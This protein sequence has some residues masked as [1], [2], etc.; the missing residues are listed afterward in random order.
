MNGRRARKKSR[1]RR[2]RALLRTLRALYPKG[3]I[4]IRERNKER[5]EKRNPSRKKQKKKSSKFGGVRGHQNFERNKTKKAGPSTV[6]APFFLLHCL[7]AIYYY[8]I[9]GWDSR[10]FVFS[11]RRAH[12]RGGEYL[13]FYYFAFFLFVC[14]CGN[15]PL[16]RGPMRIGGGRTVWPRKKKGKRKASRKNP[17][18]PES[19]CERCCHARRM[20][21]ALENT[22]EK[23]RQSLCRK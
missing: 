13:F 7:L 9:V 6:G 11:V 23:R 10:C 3:V 4:A 22:A 1:G 20:K 17:S 2:L 12:E 5:R 16:S 18:R 8:S 21:T 14:F 19:R 15:Q